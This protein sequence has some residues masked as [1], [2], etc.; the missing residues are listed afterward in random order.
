M[1]TSFVEEGNKEKIFIPNFI[2][3]K[4]RIKDNNKYVKNE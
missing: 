2:F 1:M 4:T 3:A